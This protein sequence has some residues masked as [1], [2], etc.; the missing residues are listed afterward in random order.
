MKPVQFA[1]IKLHRHDSLHSMRAQGPALKEFASKQTRERP[2]L[3]ASS[4]IALGLLPMAAY[5]S[6][7]VF[8][9][10]HSQLPAAD[11]TLPRN[12]EW[13]PYE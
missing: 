9:R 6:R 11:M 1:P 3:I 2:L 7:R 10:T 5:A 12:Q 13:Y 8:G 4:L